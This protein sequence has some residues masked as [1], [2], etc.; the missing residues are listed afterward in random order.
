[1]ADDRPRARQALKRFT[2]GSGPL[3]R[4]SDRL[5]FGARV[6]LICSLLMSIPIA[7][8]V[9]TAT[10]SQA[11]AEAAAQSAER[12]KVSARLLEDAP[13]TAPGSGDLLVRSRAPA[14][15][16]GPSGGE[17]QGSVIVLAGTKAGS[18]VP[19]WLDSAGHH[20]RRPLTDSDITGR[21]VGRALLTLLVLCTLA[22]GA[23]ECFRAALDRNRSRRW[24]TEWATVGPRWTRQVS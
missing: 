11:R 10:H 22:F 6:L 14:A 1:V 4:G 13:L 15:W 7:L 24:A 12:H 18:T 3:K 17:E 20:T 16:P 21:T 5:Q 19:I 2:L 8:A 9:A 23:Y